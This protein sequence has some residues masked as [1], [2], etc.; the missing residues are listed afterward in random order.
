[1]SYKQIDEA[2][3]QNFYNGNDGFKSKMISMFIDK[4]PV[5]MKDINEYLDQKRWADLAASAHKFKSCIDFVGAKMLREV[6]D[7]IEHHAK[8]DNVEAIKGLVTSINS[9]C[10]EVVVELQSE[11]LTIKAE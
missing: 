3:F 2:F 11:L 8:E 5:F 10:E 4:A 9:I 1:M 7:Q 6:A